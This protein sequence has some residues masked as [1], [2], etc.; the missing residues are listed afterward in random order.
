MHISQSFSDSPA[1]ATGLVLRESKRLHKAAI[2][3]SLSVRQQAVV[4]PK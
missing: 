2:S 4:I 1:T 3:A